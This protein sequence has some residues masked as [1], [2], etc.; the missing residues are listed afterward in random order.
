MRVRVYIATT[1]GP[2]LVQRLA[3]EEGLAEAELSAV[4]LDGTPTRLPIT[5][6]YTY[7]V[8]D[9]VRA[10]SGGAA[11]RLDLDRR[12]DGGSSWMLGAW[13]AHLLLAEG[14]L[15]LRDEPADA[16]V[17]ATG[18][19]A[20][21]PDAER[22][23][24]VR[25][26]GR[27]SEKIAH[28]AE[29]AAEED[30]AGRRLFLVV[31]QDN[32][33]EAEAALAD[34]PDGVR[35]RMTVHAVT[36]TGDVRGLLAPGSDAEGSED[37]GGSQRR[38]E[39]AAP[40][41]TPG[42]A[43]ASPPGPTR[44][45]GRW[46]AALL[47]CLVTVAA[48][49]GY[50]AWQR[51]ERDWRGL[52][53]GGRYLELARSLDTFPLPFL[54]RGFRDALKREARGA[55]PAVSVAARRPADGGSCAGLRF[56]GGKTAEVPVPASGGVHRL[57]RLRSL[58]GFEVRAAAPAGVAAGHA[59]IKL[60]LAAPGGARGTLLPAQRVVS[61]PLA[62]GPLRLSQGLPLYLQNSWTWTVAAVWSP[63]PSE[64]VTRLLRG[65]AG[66]EARGPLAGLDD[67]GL[68]VVRARIELAP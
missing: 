46:V 12:V 4:C 25:A 6:A 34:L 35:R 10:L 1:E 66:P 7:F 22:R 60:R 11:Y 28:L 61:G 13:I 26:V 57:E 47:L 17:F 21:A 40:A 58:C 56:R 3:P 63:V 51:V 14:R 30:G 62:Q 53:D 32:A 37:P 43:S 24:E 33:P 20:V 45:P 59:W 9:H 38:A 8:R 16:T 23:A 41:A 19:V 50:L 67:L 44:R 68:S 65:S 49:A 39:A 31:P 27:I 36:E 2:A 52:R 54:A 48:A 18:E 15:A 5:A 64:D 29:R 42:G 55:V